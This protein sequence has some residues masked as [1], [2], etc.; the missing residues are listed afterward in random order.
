[1]SVYIYSFVLKEI[2]HT[3][4]ILIYQSLTLK[5]YSVKLDREKEMFFIPYLFFQM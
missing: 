3:M 2:T 4:L 5:S 1:M